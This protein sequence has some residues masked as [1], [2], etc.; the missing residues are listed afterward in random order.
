MNINDINPLRPKSFDEFIGQ[1]SIKDNLLI[2]INAAIIRD[3]SLDHT[4]LIGYPGLG[5][6]TLAYLIASKLNRNIIV[7]NANSIERQKDI[8][9]ALSKLKSGDILFIDEIHALNKN[10]EEILYSAM[11]DFYIN[12]NVKNEAKRDMIKFDLPP[13]TLIGATT[14]VENLS[15]PLQDRFSISIRLEKYSVKDIAK[16]IENAA[17]KLN[18]NY[19]QEALKLVAERS[20]STPR[21]ALNYSKRINDYALIQKRSEIDKAFVKDVFNKLKIKKYG[22]NQIDLKYL[23]M[24][25]KDY[26]GKPVGLNTISSF[27]NESNKYIEENIEKYLIEMAFI[28]KTSRGRIITSKGI[29]YFN[30]YY[31]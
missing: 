31:R 23:K 10:I 18:I 20:K 1:N 28:R 29:T 11:E 8:V 24:L 26:Q 16:I 17:L 22:L 4:L 25:Y 3:T 27:L 21:L 12:L 30:K 2:Y 14:E 19:S 7:I 13:F 5:K 9:I 15:K 6:T